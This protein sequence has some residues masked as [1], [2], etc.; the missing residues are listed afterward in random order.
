MTHR[1]GDSVFGGSLVVGVRIK[2]KMRE[3]LS[4]AVLGLGLQMNDGHVADRAFVLDYRLRLRMI[5]RFAP[6]T[7]LPV[8]IAGRIRHHA[9]AP[10][11]A[12]GDV[13]AGFRFHSIVAGNAA[14]RGMKLGLQ[15]TLS[16]SPSPEK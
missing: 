8:W 14:V 11:E 4:L 10:I 5:E 12:D 2:W 3:D 13:L 6:H 15:R 16:R 7:S 1:A 9:G